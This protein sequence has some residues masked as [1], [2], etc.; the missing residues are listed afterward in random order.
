MSAADAWFAGEKPVADAWTP[1]P[2]AR[3]MRRSV[4]ITPPPEVGPEVLEFARKAVQQERGSSPLAITIDDSSDGERTAPCRATPPPSDPGPY[5]GDAAADAAHGATPRSPASPAD[6][7]NLTL[8]LRGARGAALDV[9]VRRTTK[10][11]TILQHYVASLGDALT[12]QEAARAQLQFEG[13]VRRDAD[14]AH[15]QRL[16]AD[17]AVQDCGLEPDDLLDVRW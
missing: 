13:E 15:R 6:D 7:S 10:V 12:P 2:G 4:S 14:A 8:T 11:A 17:T 16:G 3:Y 5:P 1:E 9:V